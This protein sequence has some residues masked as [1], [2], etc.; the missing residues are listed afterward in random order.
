DEALG[1]AEPDGVAVA[2]LDLFREALAEYPTDRKV[3]LA[4]ALE[5]AA[6]AADPRVS[7]IE[8]ADYA[9]S[10]AEAA[11]VTTTGIRTAARETGCYVTVSVLA[12][13]GDETQDGFWF[14]VGREPD[15]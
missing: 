12:T 7:G 15:A 8:S 2:D 14:S 9:D 5:R 4:I 10:L 13:E 1:L 3:D 6:R 11:V